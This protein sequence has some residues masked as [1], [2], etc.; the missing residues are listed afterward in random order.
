MPRWKPRT[1][2]GESPSARY[3]TVLAHEHIFLDLRCWLATDDP[4][5]PLLQH[6]QVGKD[7]L[8]LVRG[9]PFACPDNLVLDDMELAVRELTR[10]T[11]VSPLP[12]IIDLTPDTIGRDTKRL[13]EVSARTGIDIITGCGPYIDSSWP[14]SLH[15]A[16]AE[17]LADAMVQSLTDPDHPAGVIGEIGTSSPITPREV[18]ALTAAA[19]AHRRTGAPVFV[20]LHPWSPEGAEALDTLERHG[21][22]PARVSL[23]HLDVRGAGDTTMLTSLLDRGC[24]V[25]FD[26]WGDEYQY[27]QV[28]MPKDAERVQALLQ[29]VELGYADR[30]THSH[31]VCTRTQLTEFGGVGYDYLPRL[32]PDWL[33]NAGLGEEVVH[34]QLAGNATRLLGLDQLTPAAS[35]ESGRSHLITWQGR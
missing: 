16:S 24:Y 33:R 30:L 31:D 12:L 10:L 23:C 25:A 18:T 9:N 22:D 1:V 5:Y 21:V 20:H 2:L 3:D 27:G 32:L 35:E 17:Q 8:D 19:Q 6:Q 26:I 28:R 29:L 4:H 14:L 11:A 7:N 15:D 13:A 34:Q